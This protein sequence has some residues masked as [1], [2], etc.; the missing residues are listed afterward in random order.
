MQIKQV[1]QEITHH[2][3]SN[4]DAAPMKVQLGEH[5]H[6]REVVANIKA[7]A[8]LARQGAK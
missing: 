4:R 1:K 5:P 6:L 7:K 8:Y 2:A 3:S